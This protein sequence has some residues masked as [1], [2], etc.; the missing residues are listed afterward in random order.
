[1][2]ADLYDEFGNYVGPD[3]PADDDQGNDF[4]VRL[5]RLAIGI[6]LTPMWLAIAGARGGRGAGTRL[7][8][9]RGAGGE[10]HGCVGVG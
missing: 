10:G 8:W 2:D 7:G 1:M 5:C 6:A 4:D 9:R 3:L